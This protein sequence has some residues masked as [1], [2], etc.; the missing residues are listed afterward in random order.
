MVFGH[1]LPSVQPQSF[2]EWTRAGFEQS[3]ME[4]YAILLEERIPGCYTDAGGGNP[5]LT[6]VP[7]TDHNGSVRSDEFVGLRCRSSP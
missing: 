2:F 5:S 6:L 3:L 4:L 1:S 7:K